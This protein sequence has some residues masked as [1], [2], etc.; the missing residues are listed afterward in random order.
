[1]MNSHSDDKGVVYVAFSYEYFVMAMSS[2]RSLRQHNKKL[3]V[4]IITDIDAGALVRD[5]GFC[6]KVEFVVV[7]DD[8][9][10]DRFYKIKNYLFV[11]NRKVVYLDADTLINGDLQPLFD[12]LDRVDMAAFPLPMPPEVIG[13]PDEVNNA[14]LVGYWNSGVLAYQNDEKARSFFDEWWSN[15]VNLGIHA[16]QPSLAYTI[17]YSS[18]NVRCLSYAFNAI[19]NTSYLR[20][21]GGRRPERIRVNHYFHPHQSKPVVRE[22]FS[23]HC[24]LKRRFYDEVDACRRQEMEYFEAKYSLIMCKYCDAPMVGFIVE[25][26]VRAYLKKKY[27][28]EKALV[29]KKNRPKLRK[30]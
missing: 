9:K 14:N 24:V 10:T 15:Y 16:D 2:L 29:K 12:V 25:S 23:M 3:S 4:T 7:T 26:L 8:S 30:R 28:L 5:F 27:G 11:R 21:F 20:F 6:E 19:L 18:I 1:M 17:N 22:L 13:I